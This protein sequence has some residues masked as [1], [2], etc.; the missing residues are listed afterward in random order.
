M[1]AIVFPA[2]HRDGASVHDQENYLLADELLAMP[3]VNRTIVYA[4]DVIYGILAAR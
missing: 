2:T 1:I 4:R 3:Q